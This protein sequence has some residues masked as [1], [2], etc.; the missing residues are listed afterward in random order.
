MYITNMY[1]TRKEILNKAYHDCMCELYAKSQPMA[2]YDNLVAELKAG[3]IDEE[4]D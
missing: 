3:K 1:I 2:D 4:K